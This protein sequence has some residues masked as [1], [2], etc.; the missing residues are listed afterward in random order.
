[1]SRVCAPV[2]DVHATRPCLPSEF[3]QCEHSLHLVLGTCRYYH[4]G[5]D[6]IQDHGWGCGYRTLQT[7]V[8]WHHRRS[9][10]VDTA[11]TLRSHEDTSTGDITAHHYDGD[12]AVH[13]SSIQ[14]NH[15]S[16][17]CTEAPSLRDIQ[18]VLSTAN[19]AKRGHGHFVGS[20][21]WISTEDCYIYLACA[22][23]LPCRV[24]SLAAAPDRG[25]GDVTAL[26]RALA[27]HFDRGDGPVMIGG[28]TD[29]RSRACVGVVIPSASATHLSRQ[30]GDHDA[31]VAMSDT[32]CGRVNGDRE[33]IPHLLVLDP[34]FG[35]TLHHG[36][37][38]PADLSTLSQYFTWE[39]V[40][41]LEDDSWYNLCCPV[42]SVGMD[43]PTRVDEVGPYDDVDAT[44][45][46]GIVVEET[47]YEGM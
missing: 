46:G 2:V 42:P 30:H 32:H 26:V 10:T 1:M 43:E 4:Y 37:L 21:D 20:N 35:G 31:D 39:P 24:H 11:G 27:A 14:T 36:D 40:S 34:H 16:L 13:T 15:G 23:G 17:D 44:A 8:S 7:I 29:N 12:G 25:A 33:P 9:N 38:T 22:H 28:L 47:G 41:L 3:S 19:A 18:V 45:I 6:G 5:C